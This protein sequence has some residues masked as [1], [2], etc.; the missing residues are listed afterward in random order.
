[1][2]LTTHPLTPNRMPDLDAVFQGRG[3]AEAKRCYCMYYRLTHQEYNQNAH[4]T[5]ST[6]NRSAM[7]Q[8]AAGDPAPGLIGYLDGKPV[9]WVSL[10]PREDFHR[11]KTSRNLRQVDDQ[12]VW[13]IPCFVVLGEHRGKGLAHQMLAAAIDFARAHGATVLEAYPVDRSLEGGSKAPWFGSLTML[14]AAGFSEVA[15][16]NPTRPIVRMAL[17]RP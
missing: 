4:S 15:R 2:P 9:A 12:P 7:A 14:T 6:R 10:G 11:L 16:H 5:L 1:M 8:L 3:C 17:S 13:S